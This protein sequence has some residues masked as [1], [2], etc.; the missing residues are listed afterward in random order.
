MTPRAAP[1]LRRVVTRITFIAPLWGVLIAVLLIGLDFGVAQMGTSGQPLEILGGFGMAMIMLIPAMIVG[2][3]IGLFVAFVTSLALVAVVRRFGWSR[4][5]ALLTA[6]LPGCVLGL[7]FLASGSVLP[8][9]G[10]LIVCVGAAA[11]TWWSSLRRLLS[12]TS[13]EVAD[14][15]S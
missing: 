13:D 10:A 6:L 2:Y 14:I 7:L 1:P 9:L 8:A 4:R 12:G 11:L 3:P 5:N 15:F